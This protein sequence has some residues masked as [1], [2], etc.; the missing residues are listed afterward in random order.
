[1]QAIYEALVEYLG[2]EKL[3]VDYLYVIYLLLDKY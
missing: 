1:M 2:N 3:V